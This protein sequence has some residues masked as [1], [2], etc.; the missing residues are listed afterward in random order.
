MR[1]SCS[2]GI[3]PCSDQHR[4]TDQ[5]NEEYG[6]VLILNN[7]IVASIWARIKTLKYSYVKYSDNS[8]MYGVPPHYTCTK[9]QDDNKNCFRN[10]RN[11]LVPRFTELIVKFFFS[12]LVILRLKQL[13]TACNL[14]KRIIAII[15]NHA[16]WWV[17]ER[18]TPGR[19]VSANISNF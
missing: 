1:G 16:I 2:W 19:F 6:L 18:N 9:S 10:Y 12:L 3:W 14:Y 8:W 17:I 13:K 15:N 5:H 4:L 11:L 7:K